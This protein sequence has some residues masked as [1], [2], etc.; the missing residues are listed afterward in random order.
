VS[1]DRVDYRND[2]RPGAVEL[3]GSL[4]VASVRPLVAVR[5]IG[6]MVGDTLLTISRLEVPLDLAGVDVFESNRTIQ[7]LNSQSPRVSF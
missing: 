5:R 3:V 4:N 7:L 2:A 1:F 6:S